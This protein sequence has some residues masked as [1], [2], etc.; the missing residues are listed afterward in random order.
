M[1]DSM[2]DVP[3]RPCPS[4]LKKSILIKGNNHLH[5]TRSNFHFY[6]SS[7]LMFPWQI[8]IDD[9]IFCFKQSLPFSFIPHVSDVSP[10]SPAGPSQPPL[11]TGSLQVFPQLDS[12]CLQSL[13]NTLHM[14]RSTNHSSNTN[15][16][17]LHLSLQNSFLS[18]HVTKA[19]HTIVSLNLYLH[20]TKSRRPILSPCSTQNASP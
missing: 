18:S 15:A 8:N 11:K 17:K 13:P 20:C 16:L 14:Y 10:T 5:V 2:K 9:H 6:S 4:S 19:D 7:C 3:F 1:T 12:S